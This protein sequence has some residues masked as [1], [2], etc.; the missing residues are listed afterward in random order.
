M[1]GT[2]P[3]CIKMTRP[4]FVVAMA[5]VL[6]LILSGLSL[7]AQPQPPVSHTAPIKAATAATFAV[8]VTV[9]ATN[10]QSAPTGY[11]QDLLHVDSRNWANY[12]VSN[13]SNV[14][15]TY[16]NGT[17]IN[18]WI[19]A[20]ASNLS[21]NTVVWID[22]ASIAALASVTFYM[23]IWPLAT[24]VW[25]STG[26]AGIAP[27]LTTS[28]AAFD[29]GA[30]VFLAYENFSG[31]ATVFPHVAGGRT[32]SITSAGAPG[33]AGT[34]TWNNGVTSTTTTTQAVHLAASLTIS[35]QPAAFD[36]GWSRLNQATIP[37]AT[38]N[39]GFRVAYGCETFYIAG[40]MT[41]WANEVHSSSGCAATSAGFH[42]TNSNASF[43]VLSE[44]SFPTW[45]QAQWNYTTLTNTTTTADATWSTAFSQALNYELGLAVGP[46][47]FTDYRHPPPN[48]V[49]P[50]A[51]F[52]STSF[53]PP[54]TAPVLTATGAS[55]TSI[56]ASWTAPTNQI[57]TNYTLQW[58][59]VYGTWTGATSEATAMQATVTSLLQNT[60]YFLRVETWDHA[61][62]GIL[63]NIAVAHTL[64]NTRPVV[65]PSVLAASGAS[66]SSVVAA[67]TAPQNVTFGH[68]ALYDGTTYGTWSLVMSGI[69]TSTLEA[70][71]TGL[72]QNTTYF[73][74]VD[75][76][77]VLNTNL[78][79]S[80]IAP[81]RT[82]ANTGH[83]VIPPM[84]SVGASGTTSI[85]V[86]WTAPQN[87]TF[88]H[89]AL[90]DG[91]T[92]GTWSLVMSGIS[93]S[94]LEASVTGLVQNTT[95]FFQVDAYTVL[96]TNL[97]QSNIA[98][99]R[100][101]AN[102]G[103]E[104][105][106]PILTASGSGT[107]SIVAAWTLP[108]NVTFTHFA[109]YDGTTYGTW[110]LVMS[111]I[112][113][114]T[115]EAS[116]TGLVQNTTYFFQV[117][118]YTVLNTNLSQSNIAPARTVA[119]TGHEI[120]P[121]ILTASGSGT[122]SI[123]AAWTPPQNI[124]FGTYALYDGTT[125]G[126]W[127]LVMSG[128]SI[129]TLEASV[130]GLV[131]NTTY[132]FQVDAYT[133]LNTNLSQSNI[134]PARTVANTG[135]VV[136]PPMISVGASGTTSIV[137]AWTPPTN[138]TVANYTL[139]RGT[140]YGI[141][142]SQTSEG[143]S[144]YETN[145]TGLVQNTT[146]WFEIQAWSASAVLSTSNSA[147]VRTFSNTGHVV[148]PPLLSGAA[149]WG[150]GLDDVVYLNWTAPTNFTVTNYTILSA[151]A[152][153]YPPW[154]SMTSLGSNALETSNGQP[155]NTTWVYE[156]EAWDGAIPG[157]FSNPAVVTSEPNN[158]TIQKIVRAPI[159]SASARSTGIVVLA[160]TAAQN[161][162]VNNYTI[163]IGTTYG[164]WI[165]NISAGYALNWTVHTLTSNTTYYFQIQVWT[166]ALTNG[167][168]SN[169]AIAHTASP[170][171]APY[172]PPPFP[173]T[174]I[175]VGSGVISILLLFAAWAWED[176][177]RN[178]PEY[179]EDEE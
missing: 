149:Y 82:V 143:S 52:S 164:T 162:T 7:M 93:N 147:P 26:T 148:I 161:E 179:D 68:Y 160:W 15:F 127:S 21:T 8:N 169:V 20:N 157:P 72:V 131:Q 153:Y 132:F 125:Y 83:V 27:E 63:S 89:Y 110:S 159:L 64:A 130:T 55:T 65:I 30:R 133:V 170:G 103:H 10:G 120:L 99:A 85:V 101:V 119:N 53:G 11:F 17:R 97:S 45:V 56:I 38:D 71:V 92:Y 91:T 134:A 34:V 87:V 139:L 9:V 50:T 104:I 78:S 48:G 174:E 155:K 168:N 126:T 94:T 19:E 129:S 140:T 23:D 4:Q 39:S 51:T 3:F 154:S 81:A 46:E 171:A 80:N 138:T 86:A 41:G 33:G 156:V 42:P 25:S 49:M 73:F 152:G 109:L 58:G 1:G 117:D 116:V 67:W 37:P 135:H 166:S 24:F 29:N 70:S 175:W 137:A 95:Y 31:V 141:W 90:Y 61:L 96:N 6:M 177:K 40:K 47:Y 114:S 123:V 176:R 146:Y 76:Y 98:P 136:I 167:T 128:I 113:N 66:T 79:Q 22:L 35:T 121:P 124:T 112:S 150:P 2:P 44:I 173:W 28:Y 36:W 88:G 158:A 142:T 84:I 60:T 178:R 18:A 144:T 16:G 74:Q 12:I 59:T 13:W 163:Q 151:P 77:T 165:L 57:V 115:L 118:A 62:L 69:S 108:I 100:T 106:P 145:V 75:A 105:L 14:N 107:T 5:V 172:V 102:T 111:G 32:W 54:N 122:T 43:A